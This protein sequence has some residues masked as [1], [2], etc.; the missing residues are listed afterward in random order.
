[1]FLHIRQRRF[2]MWSLSLPTCIL[3]ITFHF[4]FKL[5]FFLLLFCWFLVDLFLKIYYKDL[6][7]WLSASLPTYPSSKCEQLIK[8]H[9]NQKCLLIT[10]RPSVSFHNI[11]LNIVLNTLDRE[12]L[13]SDSLCMLHSSYHSGSCVKCKRDSTISCIPTGNQM[14]SIASFFSQTFGSG[15]PCC[16]RLLKLLPLTMQIINKWIQT[17]VLT[18]DAAGDWVSYGA[19]PN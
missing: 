16:L 14:I 15:K 3:C 6:S 13:Y 2:V 10:R 5:S 11:K 18:M 17:G 7:V 8:T 9:Q 1:M 19:H 4:F 12:C